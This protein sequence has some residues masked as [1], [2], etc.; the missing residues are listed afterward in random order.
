MR[1]ATKQM[2]DRSEFGGFFARI[3]GGRHDDNSINSA[4]S[5]GSGGGSAGNGNI[6]T[7]GMTGTGTLDR[8]MEDGIGGGGGVGS[9][10]RDSSGIQQYVSPHPGSGSQI[11]FRKWFQKNF[12][13]SKVFVEPIQVVAVNSNSIG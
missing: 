13:S 9:S 12:K 3:F 2:L 7:G 1:R 11:S 8:H 4:G 6:G 10:S 5:A